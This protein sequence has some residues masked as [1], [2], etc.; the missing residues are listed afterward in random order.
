MLSYDDV[1]SVIL[2]KGYRFFINV[3]SINIIGVRS[4][5]STNK[6]SDY[7]CVLWMDSNYNKH[8]Q[9]FPCTTK[10]GKHW[11]LNPLNING[12]IILME[13]QYLGVYKLGIHNRSRPS[14]SYEALE[15]VKPMKYFRDNNKDQVLD[16]SGKIYEGNF[17]TNI[18]RSAKSGWSKF[19]DK[20]SA[21]CQV[22]TGFFRN[23]ETTNWERFLTLCKM[24]ERKYGNLFSYTLINEKDFRKL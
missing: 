14:R 3:D 19:V 21:G 17:K 23:T 13:G 20:W 2:K 11:L 1:K 6:F 8:I 9:T 15:Q 22:I 10:P 4:N 5:E 24:S 16:Y 18:H 12:T 7:I